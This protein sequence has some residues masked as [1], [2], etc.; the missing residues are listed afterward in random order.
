M[1]IPIKYVT[2]AERRALLSTF[3]ADKYCPAATASSLPD[4]YQEGDLIV[5]GEIWRVRST[6]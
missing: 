5:E 1:P 2:L 4:N 3:V 6:E